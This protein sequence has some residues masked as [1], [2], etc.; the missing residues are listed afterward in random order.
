M[1]PPKH[2]FSLS[3]QRLSLRGVACI[4]PSAS[5]SRA[6]AATVNRLSYDLAGPVATG[7]PLSALPHSTHEP[8]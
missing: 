1:V 3:L 4:S 8:S 7:R 2:D 6:I 5:T